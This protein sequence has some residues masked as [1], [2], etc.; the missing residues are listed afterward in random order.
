MFFALFT[1]T[2]GERVLFSLF[3]SV[4][5]WLYLRIQMV[6]ALGAAWD[7]SC[8]CIRRSVRFTPDG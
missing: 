3:G 2:R 1:S 4:P 6:S 7:F 5:F 8:T